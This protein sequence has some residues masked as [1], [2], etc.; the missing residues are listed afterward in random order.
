MTEI[1]TDVLDLVCGMLCHIHWCD[2]LLQMQVIPNVELLDL[3][4][5]KVK[6]ILWTLLKI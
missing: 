5:Y 1:Y 4:M 6:Y 2:I 3:D